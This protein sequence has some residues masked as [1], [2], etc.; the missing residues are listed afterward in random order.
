MESSRVYS[1]SNLSILS[2]SIFK[3]KRRRS[4]SG[5]SYRIQGDLLMMPHRTTASIQEQQNVT[6]L[7]KDLYAMQIYIDY[8]D[9]SQYPSS[10]WPSLKR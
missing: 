2:L 7:L 9:Y 3:L 6:Y 1:F 4:R 8:I 10:D 5:G